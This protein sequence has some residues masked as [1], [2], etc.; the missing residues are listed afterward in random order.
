MSWEIGPVHGETRC[1]LPVL[2]ADVDEELH[3][4]SQ[5]CASAVVGAMSAKKLV[6]L[7]VKT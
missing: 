5:V 1:S 4:F 7:M 6:A 3:A 2:E